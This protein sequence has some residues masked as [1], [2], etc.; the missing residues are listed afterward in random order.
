M[1]TCLGL[2]QAGGA[3]PVEAPPDL[4]PQLAIEASADRVG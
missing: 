4:P 2:A 3:G 1:A